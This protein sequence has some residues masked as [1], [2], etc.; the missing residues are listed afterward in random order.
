MEEHSSCV[1]EFFRNSKFIPYINST[2]EPLKSLLRTVQKPRK[3][4]GKT[5]IQLI[6]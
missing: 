2:A 5:L 3:T 1:K 4:T 6:S